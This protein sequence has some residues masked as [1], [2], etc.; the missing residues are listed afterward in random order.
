MSYY[1]YLAKKQLREPDRMLVE[2]LIGLGGLLLI[3]TARRNNDTMQYCPLIVYT[4]EMFFLANLIWNFIFKM[5]SFSL[6]MI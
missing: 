6:K 5:T 1:D 4:I 3:V 2:V